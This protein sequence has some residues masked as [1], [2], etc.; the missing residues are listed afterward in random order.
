MKY[1]AAYTLLALRGEKNIDAAKVKAL[2]VACDCDVDQ[3]SL[4]AVIKALEGKC[5]TELINNGM[6]KVSSM[7]GGSGA[8][9]AGGATDAKAEEAVEE[10]KEDTVEE[11]EESYSMG[12]LFG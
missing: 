8:K 12:G 10:E 9:A 6:S 3:T 4:D 2:L 1:V 11:E 5:L 7:G